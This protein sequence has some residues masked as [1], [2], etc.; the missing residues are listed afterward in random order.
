MSSKYNYEHGPDGTFVPECDTKTRKF[1][2]LHDLAIIE[3][4]PRKVADLPYFTFT[5]RNGERIKLEWFEGDLAEKLKHEAVYLLG[6]P[7]DKP[8]PSGKTHEIPGAVLYPPKVFKSLIV[9]H[10]YDKRT[11]YKWLWRREYYNEGCLWRSDF[12]MQKGVAEYDA[13]SKYKM[14]SIDGASG[15]PLAIK[16]KDPE[17]GKYKFQIIGFQNSEVV[18]YVVDNPE[19]KVEDR[20]DAIMNHNMKT[21]FSLSLPEDFIKDWS[22]VSPDSAPP[23]TVTDTKSVR[24]IETLFGAR[25][26]WFMKKLRDVMGL[27]RTDEWNQGFEEDV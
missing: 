9:G 1:A 15:C 13:D 22:I 18:Q 10:G 19:T 17:T 27:S 24:S 8:D 6:F 20:P 11:R 2:F 23:T 25:G 14:D 4:D 3:T 26:I 5:E 7:Q 21:Y 16:V 12:R